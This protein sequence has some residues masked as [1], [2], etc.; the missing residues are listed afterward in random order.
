MPT[1]WRENIEKALGKEQLDVERPASPTPDAVENIGVIDVT[2]LNT[3]PAE[4]GERQEKALPT[5]GSNLLL[6][7]FSFSWSTCRFQI[8]MR[9]IVIRTQLL[10]WFTVHSL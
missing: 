7:S 3:T 10:P 1:D 5:V 6:S 9:Q 2:I 4:N 8:C